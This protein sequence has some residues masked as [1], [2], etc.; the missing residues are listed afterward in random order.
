MLG[1]DVKQRVF[2]KHTEWDSMQLVFS[3]F[4]FSAEDI[5]SDEYDDYYY[6]HDDRSF[7]LAKPLRVKLFHFFYDE[8]DTDDEILY[9][10]LCGLKMSTLRMLFGGLCVGKYKIIASLE[11]VDDE[12][13]LV[14]DGIE[15][16]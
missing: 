11:E 10:M 2:L 4:H 9:N 5:D 12:L 6:I 15:K 8:D 3:D 16:Q 13:S 7:C 14:L 1:V